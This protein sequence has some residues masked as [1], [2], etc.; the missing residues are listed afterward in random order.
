MDWKIE[1][2]KV[3]NGF[4]ASFWEEPDE[5]RYVKQSMVF[6]EPE[7]ESGEL[8][9]MKNLL[10]FIKDHFGL[11]WSKHNKQNLNIEIQGNDDAG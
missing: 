4:V 5:G 6:E 1:A 9:A 11:N 10:W 8:E 3:S 7:T 2:E